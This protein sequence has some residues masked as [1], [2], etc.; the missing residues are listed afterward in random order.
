MLIFLTKKTASPKDLKAFLDKLVEDKLHMIKINQ[1]CCESG[2]QRYSFNNIPIIIYENLKSKLKINIHTGFCCTFIILH[3]LMNSKSFKTNCHKD[4][5]NTWMGRGLDHKYPYTY[6]AHQYTN[7]I[8][9]KKC[10]NLYGCNAL[11][12][13][14]AKVLANHDSHT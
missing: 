3:E 14:K 7:F 11:A 13:S 6:H 5:T 9:I 4:F 2:I 8:K 1:Y 10:V 12:K